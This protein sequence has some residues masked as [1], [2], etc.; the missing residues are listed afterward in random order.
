M[1][2][3]SSTKKSARQ[4]EKQDKWVVM[5]PSNR[6]ILTLPGTAGPQLEAQEFWLFPLA[7]FLSE[8]CFLSLLSSVFSP[9]SSSTL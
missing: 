4:V 2:F 1:K 9:P 8:A 3:D 7:L 6:L 5:Q